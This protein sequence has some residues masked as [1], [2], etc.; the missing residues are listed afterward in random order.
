MSK[1]AHTWAAELALPDPSM[2]TV[3]LQLGY[4]HRAG[5]KLF[6]SQNLL[7]E[8]TGLSPRAVWDAM[9]LLEI[10]G[11]IKREARSNGFRGRTS[12]AVTLSIGDAFVIPKSAIRMARKGLRNSHHVQS[13]TANLQ[14]APRAGAP[15][16]MREGIGDLSEE[17][18]QGSTEGSIGHCT[19]EAGTGRP[20]LRLL[21]GGRP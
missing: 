8:K 2:K 9:K 21:A 3:L 6:P 20:T 11:L 7:A 1:E 4:M 14:L 10:F 12:D 13:T 5:Q 17:P 15:R 16:T 18:N 19:R